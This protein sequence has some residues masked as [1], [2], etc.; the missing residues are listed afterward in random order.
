MTTSMLQRR[1]FLQLA[2][3][4]AAA[5]LPAF[6]RESLAAGTTPF[7]PDEPVELE[8]LHAMPGQDAYYKEI[9]AA[10]TAKHPKIRIRFRASPQNYP[11]AHQTILRAAI[12]KKLPDIYHPAW[13][14][15][16][17]TVR[18]LQKRNAIVDLTDL[19]SAEGEAWK[20]E[21]YWP[22]L[23]E[24]G[25]IDGRQYALPFAASTPVFFFNADL[26][27]AAGGNPDA[28][29][30]DWDGLISLGGA[31]KALGKSDGISFDIEV[32]PDDWL[33]QTVILEQG[34]ALMAPDGNHCGFNND[35]GLKALELC[36][37]IMKEGGMTMR[38]Y[39]Q[40][41]QQFAAGKIGIIASSPN[42]AR[43]FTD[44][45]GD[46][47]RLG[48]MT[49]P[50][51][52]KEKGRLPTGGNGGVILTKDPVKQKAAWEY[53]K[54]AC[55]PEGQKIAVLGSGYIPTNRQAEKPEYL[56]DFY[57]KNPL[58]YTPVTQIQYASAWQGY[59]G[60]NGVKIW[61]KQRDL[62]GLVMRGE[63]TPQEGLARIVK[64][65]EALF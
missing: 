41:R 2:A 50:R 63:L 6:T 27:K 34:G 57:K 52:N 11:E 8:L 30:Q 53:L 1:R 9:A 20:N 7:E 40:S 51:M 10:F 35:I 24:V 54:F 17:E 43:A 45:V 44:L 42:A 14:Y 46:K 32:W 4:A 3:L 28:M 19:V 36:V 38:D 5:G 58:W 49:Y 23:L 62:I 60:A 64:E 18:Q 48:C 33:W 55:G 47:F 31:I 59:K 26:V 22:A 37:R 39:E 13:I 61:H 16:E 29:P 56:G 12:T 15:F 25:Q 65:T 21:N